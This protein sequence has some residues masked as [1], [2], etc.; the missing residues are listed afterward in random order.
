MIETKTIKV[1]QVTEIEWVAA[2]TPTDALRAYAEYSDMVY[3]KNSE[4]AEE[5]LREFGEP[6]ELSPESMAH[7]SYA[8]E[9]EEPLT[10]AEELHRRIDEH[11][12]FP[13]FF[14]TSEY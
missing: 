10:F 14:A 12:E 4:E 5:Q 6:Q 3:G 8:G 13:Q 11:Q 1:W 9:G 7:Y 2:A